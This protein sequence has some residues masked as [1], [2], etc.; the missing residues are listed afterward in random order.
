MSRIV[1]SMELEIEEGSF[2]DIKKIEHHADW[3]LSLNDWPEI[4]SV[5]NVN[6]K[7][8]DSVSKVQAQEFYRNLCIKYNGKENCTCRGIADVGH[9][10]KSM[11]ISYEESEKLCNAMIKYGVTERQGGGIVI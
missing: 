4:K 10:A 7:N 5:Q 11:H 3:L 6:V 2:E 8:I 9:I 1:V